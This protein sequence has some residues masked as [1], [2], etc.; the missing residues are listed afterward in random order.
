MELN[1]GPCV[2]VISLLYDGEGIVLKL[3]VLQGATMGCARKL[4]ELSMTHLLS[5]LYV[6][7]RLHCP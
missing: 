6:L 7:R 1:A 3:T 2:T 4:V 5:R